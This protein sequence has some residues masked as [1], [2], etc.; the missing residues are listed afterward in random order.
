MKYFNKK[1][2]TLIR[3]VTDKV[4]SD[5]TKMIAT[6]LLEVLSKQS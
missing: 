3:R 4:M 5:M 6:L 2:K 1:E